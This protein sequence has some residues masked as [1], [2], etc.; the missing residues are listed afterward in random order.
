MKVLVVVDMQN[1][2]IDGSL[3]TEE[4]VQI[5]DKVREKIKKFTGTVIYTMDTHYD[6][7]FETKEG[8]NLPVKHCIKGTEGWNI[9]EGIYDGKSLVVEKNTFGS[10]ELVE[11]LKKIDSKDRI[12]S[13]ELIGL[14]TDI[15]VVSNSILIKTSFPENDV[16]VDS[17]CCAGVTS[18]SHRNAL[19]TMK[20]CH[21][22]IK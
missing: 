18:Q 1:D 4:A 19:E 21:I 20:M 11:E 6:N 9:R 7:Y 5:V 22:E 16:I 2:F 8:K 15:C 17:K 13:I 14:C 12:E 10:N 3:G